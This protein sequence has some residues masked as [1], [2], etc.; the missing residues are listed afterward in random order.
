M[1]DAYCDGC[2]KKFWTISVNDHNFCASCK[3]SARRDGRLLL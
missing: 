3:D 1:P 2:H